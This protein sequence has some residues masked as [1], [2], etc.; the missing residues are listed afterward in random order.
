MDRIARLLRRKVRNIKIDPRLGLARVFVIAH[1]K[2][3]WPKDVERLLV[4]DGVDS[5]PAINLPGQGTERRSRRKI[6][7]ARMGLK[8]ERRG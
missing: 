2:L 3:A 7:A 5:R 6:F 8:H 4:E 1:Q